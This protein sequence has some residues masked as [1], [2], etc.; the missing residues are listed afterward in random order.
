MS[1]LVWDATGERLYETGVSN[2]VLYVQ[3]SAG[4]GWETGVAWNGL[5]SVTESPDGGDSNDIY[6][7]DIRT[8]LIQNCHRRSNCASGSSMN[9]RHNANP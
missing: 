4:T 8:Y 2:G 5:S 6:A 9:I 3:N 1:R 7:D